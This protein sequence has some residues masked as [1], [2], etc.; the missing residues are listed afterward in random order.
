MQAYPYGELALVLDCQDL[1]R[2]ADFWSAALGYRRAGALWEPY[3]SL[4]PDGG[5]QGPEL[6]LQRVPEAKSSQKNRLHLDLRTWDLGAELDRL[7]G[8]GA[9]VLTADPIEEGGWTWY[10]LADPEG[11]EFCVLQPPTGYGDDAAS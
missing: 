3:V 10:V 8:V 1:D 6:L 5:R 9:Q 2:C 11:N 7:R 4:R